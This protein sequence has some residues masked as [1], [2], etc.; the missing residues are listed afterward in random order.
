MTKSLTL[1]KL[2]GSVI[3]EKAKVLTANIVAIRRLANEIA[4]SRVR[5]LMIV[6]GGGSFGHPLA[7]QYAIQEGFTDPSQLIGINKTHHAMLQLNKIVVEALIHHNIPAFP[8]VPASCMISK[9]GRINIFATDT[10]RILLEMDLVPVLFGDVVLDTEKGFTI[11]SGDQ[12]IAAVATRFSAARIIMAVDVD[13]LFTDDPKTN[14]SAELLRRLTPQELRTF[15]INRTG[16]IEDAK[17]L[18]VTGGML[19]KVAE[20]LLAVEAGIPTLII[21]AKKDNNLRMVLTTNET[22]GTLIA[23]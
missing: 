17:I 19:G 13:G 3:T 23:K 11:I 8:V 6:H 15:I 2:G 22:S 14:T 9:D 4:E 10:L 5:K 12:I 1:V 7:Q 20:L 18:D 16:K 21:N